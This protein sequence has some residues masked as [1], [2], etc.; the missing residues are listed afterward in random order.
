MRTKPSIKILLLALP[1]V[2]WACSDPE[3]VDSGGV[4]LQV[5][6]VNAPLRIGVNDQ[7]VVRIPSIEIE[8]IAPNVSAGTSELMNVQLDLYEVT[9]SRRDTGTRVPAPYV[10]SLSG[11]VPVSGNLT[12]T[13]FPVMSVEQMRNPPLSDLLFEN[14][15]FDK[16]TGSTV[17][18][19]DMTF[20]VFG[21]TLGGDDVASLP[22]TDSFEFVPTAN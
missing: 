15:G 8:N 1:L 6:F 12:L 21:R 18:R 19:I 9:F 22:R 3:E 11:V 20:I 10:F 7:D 5:Q 14:G 13:D 4:V 16:E 17:I 2:L